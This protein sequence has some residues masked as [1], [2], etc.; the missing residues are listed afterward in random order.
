MV[1]IA[2]TE[3]EPPPGERD[4]PGDAAAREPHAAG[5]LAA[6][7]ALWRS[8]CC[9]S[10]R[11]RT[12][13]S[14]C[15]AGRRSPCSRWSRWRRSAGR[16][17]VR[18]A[19][20]AGRSRLFAF[21]AW[22]LLSAWWADA[23]GAAVEGA[24][25]NVLY[26]ALFALPILTL[27]ARLG[28]CV[29]PRRRHRGVA[30]R[31]RR[32]IGRVLVDGAELVPRRPPGRPRRATATAPRRCS[33]WRSGRCCG[34][35][36]RAARA[37][38]AAR[39]GF[40]LAVLRARARLPDPVAR[41]AARLR[42]R[43]RGGARARPRPAAPRVAR[44][45]SPSRRVAIASPPL[46][47][48]LRRVPRRRATT[49]PRPST[50]RVTALRDARRRGVRRRRCCSRCSTAAC[51]SARVRARRCAR[52]AAG[53]LALLRVGAVA[54]GLA[55]VG[56]PVAFASDKVRRVQ[57]ARR[58]GAGRD[59][60]RLHRRA[61]L[62]PVAD[63]AGRS[64]SGAGRRASA[65]AAIRSGYYRERATDR[66]LVD[67]HSLAAARA[68]RDGHRRRAAARW[69]RSSPRRRRWPRAG[70][71]AAPRSAAGRPALAA[72]GAVVLG[73]SA[74]DWLWL[75][76][77]LIGLGLRRAW[78]R[79]WRSWRCPPRGAAAAARRGAR[80][81][82]AARCVPLAAAVRRRAL[83]LSDVYVRT[84]AGARARRR[85]QR[86]ARRPHAPSG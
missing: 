44:R 36:A 1:G 41:R 77:G 16:N 45:C 37:P 47:D 54:G 81:R 6:A 83:F 18:G 71:R 65:R 68:R 67:P 56:D 17:G 34:R 38:A 79:R 27:P 86:L 11:G 29:R 21:A 39:G 46:L 59:A 43:R 48:A 84:R 75:I 66:N 19:A 58:R 70:A 80:W 69:P 78:R 57:A 7:P 61:A 53:A 24:G 14:R 32:D 13:R 30:A 22:S 8:S 85:P 3:H 73:Q 82:R 31:G 33:R 72:A 9:S 42:L 4:A 5:A 52:V 51:G 28:A 74:V 2:A 25:R 76:P 64:S 20:R 40:S 62:R 12:A 49:D 15:A 50:R 10:P 60:A 63:R 26:A 55:A 23:P 35:G